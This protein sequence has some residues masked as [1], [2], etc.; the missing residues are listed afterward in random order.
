MRKRAAL[1]Q[2]YD[3]GQHSSASLVHRMY[4]NGTIF[5]I[6]DCLHNQSTGYWLALQP[7]FL[8]PGS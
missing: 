2:G 7:G 3:Q 8:W 6:V 1:Q 4:L 5:H